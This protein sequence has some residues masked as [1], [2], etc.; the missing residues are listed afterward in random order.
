MSKQCLCATGTLGPTTISWAIP[1]SAI[2]C[3]LRKSI[4]RTPLKLPTNLVLTHRIDFVDQYWNDVFL[5]F[6]SNTKK[7]EHPIRIFYATNTSSLRRSSSMLCPWELIT[8]RWVIMPGNPRREALFAS[9]SGRKQ[10][11]NIF[12]VAINRRTAEIYPLSDRRYD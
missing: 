7:A 2:L 3:V 9:G 8:S 12:F 10:R 4:T 5:Y 11:P 6:L 1:Q